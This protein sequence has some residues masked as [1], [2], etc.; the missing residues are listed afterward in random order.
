MPQGG[1]AILGLISALPL[2]YGMAFV[3]DVLSLPAG[4]NPPSPLGGVDWHLLAMVLTTILLI[5]YLRS[6]FTSSKFS[7]QKRILWAI[8]LFL[9]SIFIFPIFWYLYVWKERRRT[10]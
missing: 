3:I 5:W 1:A 10:T 4:I 7:S 2:L 8:A 6:L 9:G